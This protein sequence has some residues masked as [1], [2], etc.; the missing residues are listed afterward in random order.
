MSSKD[1]YKMY[2]LMEFFTVKHSFNNVMIK[3]LMN[4]NEVWLTNV[5]SLEYNVIRIS[6]STLDETYSQSE[7]II[8]YLGTISKSFK[9]ETKF[10][11]I[12]ISNEKVEENEIFNSICINTNY[13]SG[14]DVENSFP[15]IK[16]VIHDV[17]NAEGELE[18]RISSINKN[19]K[20]RLKVRKNKLKEKFNLSATNIIILICI[21]NYLINFF[22]T[23]KGY[24]TSAIF[25][26]LGADYKMFSLGLHEL[27]RLFTYAFV[28]SSVLHLVLNMY[29]LYV[30]GN[31]IENKYGSVKFLCILFTS[32]I[33]GGLT[34][35]ILTDNQLIVGMSGGIYGLFSIYIIYAISLGAYQNRSFIFLLFINLMLN[36]VSNIA[37]QTHLGGAI[38]G[39][40]F[41][42]MFKDDNKVDYKLAVLALVVIVCLVI[43]YLSIKQITPIYMGTDAEVVKIFDDLGFKKTSLNLYN[44][45]YNY[46]INH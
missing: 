20:D 21:V 37:W 8:N 33:V 10:L 15:L 4:P 35:G 39:L 16:N 42:F 41:Y 30:L 18:S 14:I 19:L 13:Y 24:S 40:I 17:D 22:L 38:V 1:L 23:I 29:S 34:H 25:V 9:T 43:K 28:H 6:L 46:Y 31:I 12:H 26:V 32:I 27:Y 36:F 44:K 11:D 5:N 2:Q 7:R 3:E 45:L